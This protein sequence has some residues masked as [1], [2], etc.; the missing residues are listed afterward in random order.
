MREVDTPPA[1][2]WTAHDCQCW[3]AAA[4]VCLQAAVACGRGPP[5]L[6]TR[7]TRRR[8]RQRREFL[9]RLVEGR[10]GLGVEK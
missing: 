9:R 7:R 1:A 8:R 3:P 6:G 4:G 10:V 2:G 5:G